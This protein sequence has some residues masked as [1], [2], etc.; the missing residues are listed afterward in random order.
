LVFDSDFF[1]PLKL[2]VVKKKANT[3]PTLVFNHGT[4]VGVGSPKVVTNTPQM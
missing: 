4:G 1:K 3:H 2:T